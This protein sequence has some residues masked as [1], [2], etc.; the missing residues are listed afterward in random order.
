MTISCHLFM[1]VQVEVLS[2][3][4]TFTGRNLMA[5]TVQEL[6]NHPANAM[7]IQSDAHESMDKKLAWGIEARLVDHTV[8][9]Q[10]LVCDSEILMSRCKQWKY[11]FRV[12]RP[13]DVAPTI[14][15]DDGDEIEFG[16]GVGGNQTLLRLPDPRVC[17][18]HLAIA[19]VFAASGAAEVF[20]K[21]LDDDKRDFTGVPVYFGGPFAADDVLMRKLEAAVY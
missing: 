9:L 13:D 4:E 12:V 21:Y 7:N 1:L 5:D 17:N 10:S 19:R 2:A 3:I 18:L 20:D 11:Y 14:P 6:I 15:L 8:R 16:C